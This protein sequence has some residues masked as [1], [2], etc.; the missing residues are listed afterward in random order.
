M[1]IGFYGATGSNDFGDYAMMVHNINRILSEDANSN[2]YIFTPNKFCTLSNLI[3]NMEIEKVKRN[4]HIIDEPKIEGN[5]LLQRLAFV[6]FKVLRKDFLF[7]RRFNCVK[8]KDYRY[9]NNVFLETISNLDILIFNGG[10]YLQESWNE[11]NINF[12]IACLVAKHKN[13]PVYFLGNSIGPL[14]KYEKIV[15]ETVNNVDKIIVRDGYNYTAKLLETY[16]CNNYMIASDDLLFVNDYY[17]CCKKYDNYI[18]IEIMFYITRAKNGAEY[19]IDEL[20]K[21]VRIVLEK[22]NVLLVNF[23][24]DDNLAKHYIDYISN[25]LKSVD[26][27]NK[28]YTCYSTSNIYDMFGY[29]KYADFSISFKYHPVILSLGSNVPC[30]G[31]ICD[32]NG[33]YEGKMKGAF[34]SCGIDYNNKVMHIDD[35]SSEKLLEMYHLNESVASFEIQNRDGL[36]KKYNEFL[37]YALGKDR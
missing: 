12:A 25:Q 31:I 33:Y 26:G 21:F 34:D 16:D 35:F 2:I 23:D 20:I 13:I 5:S 8:K 28:V 3:N 10:G 11:K 14:G 9:L 30:V 36:K 15:M 18:I 24:I 6:F 7:F 37:R 29:Y 27:N 1:N 22:K 4:I 19:V 32:N 17:N